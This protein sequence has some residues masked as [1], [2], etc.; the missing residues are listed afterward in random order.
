MSRDDLERFEQINSLIGRAWNPM[1]RRVG[2]CCFMG[3]YRRRGHKG[4]HSDE[5]GAGGFAKIGQS[6]PETRRLCCLRTAWM[7]TCFQL[8][9][10][11]G[12]GSLN[13]ATANPG[14]LRH[15]ATRRII[16]R[17]RPPSFFLFSLFH[18][19]RTRS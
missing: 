9:T 3:H 14:L 7:S 10:D 12:P 4:A 15:D 8:K 5:E 1:D 19:P 6:Q 13:I 2:T 18:P 11:R 17:P 16:L